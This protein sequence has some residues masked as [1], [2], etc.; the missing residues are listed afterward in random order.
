MI[1]TI[2]ILFVFLSSVISLQAQDP[3]QFRASGPSA[4]PIGEVFRISY[5]VNTEPEQFNGPRLNDFQ[6][7]GPMLSTNMSTQIING[8]VTRSST[9]TYNYTVQATKE[10]TFRIEPAEITVK[11][12][13]YRSNTLEIKVVKAETNNPSNP[14][15]RQPD[16]PRTTG[17]Q[18]SDKDLFVRVELNKTNVFKG[19]Q[20]LSTI[21]IYSR[22]NLARFGEIKFP[23]FNGFLSHEIPTSEQITLQREV[24]DGQIYNVGILKRHILFPQQTGKIIIEPFELECF[25]NIQRTSSRS[26]FDMFGSYQTI[27]RDVTSNPL[28]VNV[29]ELPAPVP[30]SF[31]GAVGDLSIS[32]QLDRTQIERNEAINLKITVQG[33]GNLKLIDLPSL[34]FPSGLEVYDPKITDNTQSSLNGM[35]GSKSFDILIIPREAGDFTIPDWEFTFFNPGSGQFITRNISG[36]SIHVEPGSDDEMVNVAS[37]VSREDIRL[38]GQ[39]IRFIKTGSV[40]FERAGDYFFGSMPFWLLYIVGILVFVILVTLLAY[41]FKRRADAY[42]TRY[43]KA[44]S[45]ARKQL[46]ATHRLIRNSDQTGVP[47]NLINLVWTYLSNKLGLERAEI[48]IDGIRMNLGS[49]GIEDK[50]TEDLI[51]LLEELQF[52]QYAPGLKKTDYEGMIKQTE[53]I[54]WQIDGKITRRK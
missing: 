8:Q 30:K 27:S 3:V 32:S 43:R 12:K 51:K 20:I 11:G 28:T 31:T 25:I 7:N 33:N 35:Q 49:Y 41:H 54:I 45:Q 48:D 38:I 40:R 26:I 17:A 23:S 42:G 24:I 13:K 1:R 36:Y 44:L 47:M 9:F 15:N 52:Q 10:G 16:Q 46:N 2:Q 18:I 39:D 37:G 5:V 53:R 29:K 50:Y 21:K 19:E 4:V 14:A 6:F 22:V 34:N